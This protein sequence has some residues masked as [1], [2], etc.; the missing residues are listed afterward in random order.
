VIDMSSEWMI[1]NSSGWPI[2][3]GFRNGLIDKIREVLRLSALGLA[4]HQISRSCSIVQSTV[5]RYLKLAE[6]A[7]LRWPLPEDLSEQ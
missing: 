3:I 1:D 7:Q 2:F 5:D 4:Q 6:A